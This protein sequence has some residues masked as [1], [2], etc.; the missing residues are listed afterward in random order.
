MTEWGPGEVADG[1]AE[2]KPGTYMNAWKAKTPRSLLSA[3]F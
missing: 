3:A 2:L 1:P